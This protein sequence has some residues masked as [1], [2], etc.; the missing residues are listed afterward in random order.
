MR[1]DLNSLGQELLYSFLET[2]RYE[3]ESLPRCVSMVLGI[4]VIAIILVTRDKS[5]FRRGG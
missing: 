3:I 5:Y 2:L 4:M 1:D